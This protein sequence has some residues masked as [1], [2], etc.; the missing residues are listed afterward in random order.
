MRWVFHCIMGDVWQNH[1]PYEGDA[2]DQANSKFRRRHGEVE[3]MKP[4]GQA[5]MG[6]CVWRYEWGKN[7]KL[8]VAPR[9]CCPNTQ[10]LL[11]RI[12][13]RSLCRTEAYHSRDSSPVSDDRNQRSQPPLESLGPNKKMEKEWRGLCGPTVLFPHPCK[14]TWFNGQWPLLL[15]SKSCH[16]CHNGNI[17]GKSNTKLTN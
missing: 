12:V 9:V 7:D 14:A 15:L 17:I 16:C 4:E 2:R 10:N 13:P 5:T 3:E 1:Q 6:P 11:I 8:R